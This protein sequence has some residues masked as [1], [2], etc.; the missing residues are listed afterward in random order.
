[1]IEA[2]IEGWKVAIQ[3]DE[4]YQKALSVTK[5]GKKNRQEKLEEAVAPY[6]KKVYQDIRN[7][8]AGF[9]DLVKYLGSEEEANMRAHA[10]GADFALSITRPEFDKEDESEKE[11]MRYEQAVFFIIWGKLTTELMAPEIYDVA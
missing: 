10:F 9:E 5:P 8:Q 3:N 1:M 6:E 4:V 7:R 11:R 2:M